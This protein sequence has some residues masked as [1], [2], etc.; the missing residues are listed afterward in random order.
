MKQ[1][2]GLKRV[3]YVGVAMVTKFNESHCTISLYDIYYY[4]KNPPPTTTVFL[5][6]IPSSEIPSKVLAIKQFR[7]INYISKMEFKY[8]VWNS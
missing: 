8:R 6:R 5:F 1:G 4:T 3:T 2:K 7:F